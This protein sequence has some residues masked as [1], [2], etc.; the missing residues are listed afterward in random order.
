LFEKE[1]NESMV[2]LRLAAKRVRQVRY[3]NQESRYGV[4]KSSFPA[5]LQ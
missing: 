3:L 4:L 1:I 5:K 2:W